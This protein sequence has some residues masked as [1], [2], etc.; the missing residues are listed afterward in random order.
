M[1]STASRTRRSPC[2]SRPAARSRPSASP[3]SRSTTPPSPTSRS[4]GRSSARCTRARWTRCAGRA[5]ERSSTT[6]SSPSRRPTRGPRAVPRGPPRRRRRARHDRDRRPRRHE[7]ARR[8]REPR[9]AGAHAASAN[10]E[11][12]RGG[13][14]R[15]LPLRAS[16]AS[17]VAVVTR[18]LVAAEPA[19]G[20]FD[21]AGAWIDYAGPRGTVPTVSFSD[22]VAG[23]ADPELLPRPRGG[24]RRVAPPPSRTST[25][26]R[27]PTTA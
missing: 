20:G 1:C 7:R 16:A 26:R 6:S 8:R 27:P 4:S 11:T 21:R 19:R 2:A 10:L 15:R 5:P 12:D 18:G 23:R 3:S 9:R 17:H 24:R 22:L 14:I 13:V 25:R